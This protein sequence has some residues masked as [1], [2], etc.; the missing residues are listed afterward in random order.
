MYSLSLPST[1]LIG[2]I[3]C[4]VGGVFLHFWVPSLAG[5]W[6]IKDNLRLFSVARAVCRR[7]VLFCVR[8]SKRIR[9]HAHAVEILWSALDNECWFLYP[10]LLS[11]FEERKKKKEKKWT[12]CHVPTS[13]FSSHRYDTACTSPS[14]SRKSAGDA[15]PRNEGSLHASMKF[16]LRCQ[17][18][19][20]K[21]CRLWFILMK[22]YSKTAPPSAAERVEPQHNFW[23]LT[24]LGLLKKKKEKDE[25]VRCNNS[26]QL[27]VILKT[28]R[29]IKL[30][31]SMLWCD[32]VEARLCGRVF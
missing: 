23:S 7:G 22:L 17:W 20:E 5:W 3:S 14:R 1:L 29:L 15:L 32:R 27:I 10:Y 25:H 31:P 11:F 9:P 16:N 30:V 8:V 4:R 6:F 26:D 12:E 21:S 24:S 13:I 2:L 28:R 19:T 18:M